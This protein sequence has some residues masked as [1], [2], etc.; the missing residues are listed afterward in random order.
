[1][2]VLPPILSTVCIVGGGSSAHVLIPF[3][4]QQTHHKIHL[5]TRRPDDWQDIVTCELTDMKN[6]VLQSFHGRIDKKSHDP[7]QVIPE[8]DI[9]ILCMPVH[10]Y[11]AVLTTVGPFLSKTK[12]EVYVGTIYGQAGFNWMAHEMEKTF[13]LRNV[14]IFAIGLMTTLDM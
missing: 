2:L 1:M 6:Q 14:I 10:Q 13:N 11:R 7:H 3:L 8:A 5:L 12:K 9:I 4:S